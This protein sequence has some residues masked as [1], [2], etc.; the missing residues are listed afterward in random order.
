MHI[1]ELSVGADLSRPQPIYRP[2]LHYRARGVG[3]SI[4][5]GHEW[6]RRS[7]PI[8]ARLLTPC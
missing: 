5:T 6:P 7:I 2:S 4:R 3:Q 8:P 1:D